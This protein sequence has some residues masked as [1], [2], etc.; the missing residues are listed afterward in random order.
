MDMNVRL[1][2]IRCDK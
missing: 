1:D 2:R